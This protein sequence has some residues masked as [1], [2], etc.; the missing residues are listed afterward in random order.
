MKNS[1]TTSLLFFFF[2]LENAKNLGRSDDNKRWKKRGSPYS[3]NKFCLIYSH[4][5]ICFCGWQR[6]YTWSMT[7]AKINIWSVN[8]TEG[9]R[10]SQIHEPAWGVTYLLKY[11]RPVKFFFQF[12]KALIFSRN[13]YSRTEIWISPPFLLP[14]LLCLF[15]IFS[16]VNFPTNQNQQILC[17]YRHEAFS[18][19]SKYGHG[20]HFH[21]L[22]TCK[23]FRD[24]LQT[25]RYFT[26]LLVQYFFKE[27][28]EISDFL[29]WWSVLKLS[30]FFEGSC[31]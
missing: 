31:Y 29:W 30:R 19:S 24:V 20:S 28:S 14:P 27:W 21:Q 11:T 23:N 2:F 3:R 6:N 1:L 5:V 15:K 17:P 12:V 18:F 7:K 22:I 8:F 16:S 4:L 10:D 25:F 9:K 13:L 26:V